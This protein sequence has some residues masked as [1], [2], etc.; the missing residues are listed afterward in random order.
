MLIKKKK[1]NFQYL[2][3]MVELIVVTNI[4]LKMLI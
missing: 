1:D 4:S 3:L 2:Y